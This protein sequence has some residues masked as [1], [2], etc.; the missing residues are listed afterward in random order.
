MSVKYTIAAFDF[1]NTITTKD[2]LFHFLKFTFGKLSFY[3]KM[4]FLIPILLLFKLKIYS[5]QKTKEKVLTMFLKGMDF[6]FF[7]IKC[8]NF[9][10]E[11]KKIENIHAIKKLNWHK[12][13][14]HKIVII[15]ASVEDWIIPWANQHNIDLVLATKLEVLEGKLTGKIHLKNCNGV[16]K[17]KRLL[18]YFPAKSEYVLYA[19]GDS[20]GDK[21][22]LKLAEFSFYRS[23]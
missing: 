21:E 8:D 18:E 11:I 2:T 7:K 20:N 10:A 5:N 3:K 22:L 17:T 9:A 19:Y 14:L 6:N 1:D 23:F 13:N 4:I 12:E 16:E 15:S